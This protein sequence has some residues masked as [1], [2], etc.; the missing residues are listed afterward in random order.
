MPLSLPN[1]GV[2]AAPVKHS[3]TVSHQGSWVLATLVPGL[4]LAGYYQ[5]LLGSLL[6]SLVLQG[7]LLASQ[8]PHLCRSAATQMIQVTKSTAYNAIQ[9]FVRAAW[10]L[11]DSPRGRRLRKKIE[12]EFFTLIL[13]GGNGIC[14]V[15]FWPGWGILA[16][17]ALVISLCCAR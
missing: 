9:L 13:G 14:L 15:L 1:A 5:Q 10:T 12:F 4:R 8:V 16:V 6:L 2:I 11:W 7:S 17:T 3:A